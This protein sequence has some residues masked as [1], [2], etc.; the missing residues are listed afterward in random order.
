MKFIQRLLIILI[1]SISGCSTPPP[2]PASL[3]IAFNNYPVTLDPRKSGDFTSASLICLLYEGL[4]R[5]GSKEIITPAIA[6]KI[7]LSLDAKTYIFHLRKTFWT[8]GNPLTAADF[9]KSWKKSIDPAFPS[10]SVYLFS[11]IKNVEKYIQGKASLEEVGIQVID[12]YTLRVELE[13]PTPYF[14]SLT[15]FPSYLPIPSHI[16]EKNPKWDQEYASHLISNGPFQIEKILP[17]NEILLTKNK[18]FWNR[19]N[20]HLKSIHI[21]ILSDENTAL[22]MFEREELDFIGGALCP[23]PPDALTDLKNEGKLRFIPME[24]ST[25]CT[26][27]MQAFPFNN[28]SLRKAFSYAIHRESILKEA[29]KTGQILAKTLLPPTLFQNTSQELEFGMDLQKARSLFQK[30]LDELNISISDLEN[31]TLYY[32]Q[33]QDNQRLAQILQKDWKNLLGVSLKIEPLDQKSHLEKLHQ[34][35]YQISLAS[36][37]CQ[38]HDPVSLLDRFRS[39]KNSKN[40]PGWENDDYNLLLEQASYCID[41][42]QRESL[43]KEAEKLLLSEMPI[44]PLYHWTAPYMVHPRIKNISTT[45]TGGILFEQFNSTL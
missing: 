41:P 32:R 7:D 16:E 28:P 23:I 33:G 45:L 27:N 12:A 17:N 3:R 19:K 25:F 36:W 18:Q 24:A 35:N 34:R 42:A 31:I 9:E 4:T 8:D 40:Y 10:L 13:R 11:P 1:C 6:H 2:N 26:F 14:L 21:S 29:S 5:C 38:F 30:G 44:T 39:L 15:A 43:L 20:I 22:Q 37:I